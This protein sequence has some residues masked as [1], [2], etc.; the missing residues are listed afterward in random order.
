V[1]QTFAASSCAVVEGLMSSGTRRIIRFDTQTANQGTADCFFGNPVNNPLF[2]WA[3]CHAHYHFKN[4]IKYVLRDAGGQI[5]VTGLKIGSCMLDSFRWDPNSGTTPKY[6]CSNQ[7]IQRGWGDLYS[8]SL[9]GQWIDITGVPDGSYTLD[10][11]ANPMGVIQEA[12]YANNTT[13]IPIS[14][15]LPPAPPPN[16]NLTN[17]IALPGGSPSII[18][19]SVSATKEPGEPNH[20]GNSGGHS[21]WYAWTAPSSSPVT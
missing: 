18:G 10:M 12:S 11:Q 8:S 14:I 16:D 17:A 3:P 7:G 21:V 13:S 5:V 20:A 4:Y 19:T 9:D 6:T 15:G 1:T 2:E